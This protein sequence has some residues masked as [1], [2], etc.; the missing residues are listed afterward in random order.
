[1]RTLFSHTK[2]KACRFLVGVS[3]L[4]L[5]TLSMALEP[6]RLE[7]VSG[8]VQY[9]VNDHDPWKPAEKGL[10]VQAPVEFQ[11]LADGSALLSQA[12]SEFEL[13]GGARI[14][15]HANP[16]EPDGLVNRIKQWFGTVF[17]RIE[18]Q[19]DEFSVETPFLVSTVKGTRFVIVTTETS[20]LVTL[21]EGALEVLDIASEQTQMMAPGDVVGVGE[22]QAGIQTFQQSEQKNKAAAGESTS[23]AKPVVVQEPAR[24][25]DQLEELVEL[26]SVPMMGS[27]GDDAGG[28]LSENS[29]AEMGQGERDMPGDGLGLDA[30]ISVGG[31]LDL[32]LGLGV[33]DGL[34]VDL[35]VGG[36]NLLDLDVGL[37]L[38]LEDGP[39]FIDNDDGHDFDVDDGFDQD[40]DDGQD[41]NGL[42]EN[43]L[44]PL[45][46]M[47]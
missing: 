20:S 14:A 10:S 33:G 8:Q 18:R 27:R 19:P 41:D 39:A 21:T 6:V 11:A 29:D 25:E 5:A 3:L 17:Y 38:G 31:A 37:D 32:G 43:V 15:L 45:N 9:R 23:S 16:S 4:L 28:G 47:L 36:E 24:F 35:D 22:V 12:G 34:G 40:Q 1:M 13:K 46:S 26:G 30:G 7:S 42:L 2:S 44:K